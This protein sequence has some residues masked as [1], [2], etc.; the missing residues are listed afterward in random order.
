MTKRITVSLH[1]FLIVFFFFF[2]LPAAALNAAAQE[3]PAPRPLIEMGIPSDAYML[4]RI[5][6]NPERDFLDP[7]YARVMEAFRDA[8][9]LEEIGSIVNEALTDSA[10][11]EGVAAAQALWERFSGL[12]RAV[13]W[14]AFVSDELVYGISTGFPSYIHT[15]LARMDPEKAAANFAALDALVGALAEMKPAFSRKEWTHGPAK[16]VSLDFGVPGVSMQL[17]FANAGGVIIFSSVEDNVRTAVDLVF[18]GETDAESLAT[19]AGYREAMA[20]LPPAEDSVFYIEM[21]KIFEMFDGLENIEDMSIPIGDTVLRIDTLM[22]TLERHIFIHDRIAA[23]GYTHDGRSMEESV[24]I[25]APGWS[26]R[27]VAALVK[28]QPPVKDFEKLV[29]ADALS[30][31]VSSGFDL[32]ALHDMLVEGFRSHVPGMAAPMLEQWAMIQDGIG[33]HLRDDLL[34]CFEGRTVN[35]SFHAARPTPFGNTDS[36][37]LLRLKDAETMR[38]TYGRW[39]GALEQ[40]LEMLGQPRPI[41]PATG[42]QLFFEIVSRLRIKLLPVEMEGLQDG[43]KLTNGIMPYIRPVFGFYGDEF[44]MASS[45]GGLKNY[46]EFLEGEQPGILENEAF[47]SMGLKIPGQL[48]FIS[49]KDAGAACRELAQFL[50]MSGMFAGMIPPSPETQVARRI[51]GLLPRLSPVVGAMDFFGYAATVKGCDAEA[52]YTWTRKVT[53]YRLD[54]DSEEE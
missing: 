11:E 27:P 12:L 15:V 8:G 25:L 40:V 21:P 51:F 45:E 14:K 42:Q 38:A 7:H 9:I 5:M 17:T 54:E 44:V 3:E 46:L 4:L 18:G 43:R 26:E 31:S 19:T 49:F 23:V 6:H 34:A 32:A 1:T 39:M 2:A 16:A 22:H 35:V 36:V 50:G 41:D 20:L 37:T 33:F 52:G 48:T 28:N 13:D 10:G 24:E 53:T 30:F 29:P 47:T